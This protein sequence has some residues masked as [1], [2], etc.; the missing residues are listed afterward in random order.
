MDHDT[1]VRQEMTEKYLLNELDPAARDEFEEHF[2]DCPMCA[3]DVRAGSLFV[4]QSKVV[5]ARKLEKEVAPSPIRTPA[6]DDSGWLAWLSP[7]FAAPALALLLVII[8]F[9]NLVT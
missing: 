1:V 7:A 6:Q 9:Q 2:F 5:L 4:E 8:A 3:L